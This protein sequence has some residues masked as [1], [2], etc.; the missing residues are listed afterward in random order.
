MP[1]DAPKHPV[2]VHIPDTVGALDT[3]VHDINGVPTGVSCKTCHGRGGFA[4][5]KGVPENFHEKM[6]VSHGTN[7]CY[8]CH[9]QEDRTKLH[10]ANGT[11]LNFDQSQQLCAQCHGVQ[12][13]DY[14][15]GSH[16]G[17]NGYWDLQ[18][19]PRDRNSCLSCH[20]PHTPKYAKVRPVHPPKDRFLEWKRTHE[21]T[22]GQHK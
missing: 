11:K 20:S 4:E 18:R 14:Q 19:G 17:M 9:D 8:S 2:T 16:G 21:D 7:T 15:H 1:K 6:K 22:K 3:S 10:L 12:H 13:R 5:L